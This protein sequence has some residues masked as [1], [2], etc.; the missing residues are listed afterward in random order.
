MLAIKVAKKPV[1]PEIPQKYIN[2]EPKDWPLPVLYE[3]A[4]GWWGVGPK[5]F[6]ERYALIHNTFEG[7]NTILAVIEIDPNGW[8]SRTE[9]KDWQFSGR[10]L[11]GDHPVAKR[12]VG[13]RSPIGATS[14]MMFSYFSDPELGPSQYTDCACGCGEPTPKTWRPGHDQ[15]AIHQRIADHFGGDTLSFVRWFDGLVASGSVPS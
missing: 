12:W 14:Q 4:R 9:D 13:Q 2:H 8:K 11:T 10:V 7:V 15:R 3:A 1:R 6:Q 5:A